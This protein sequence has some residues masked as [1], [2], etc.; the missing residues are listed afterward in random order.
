MSASD[1]AEKKCS[2][3]YSMTQPAIT[4]EVLAHITSPAHLDIDST[5]SAA[6]TF[7]VIAVDEPLPA[8]PITLTPLEV[9]ASCN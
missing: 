9:V 4:G 7:V 2:D 1:F 6:Q 3:G 5:T 8:G